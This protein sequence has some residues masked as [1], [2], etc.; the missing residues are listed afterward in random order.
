MGFKILIIAISMSFCLGAVAPDREPD[1]KSVP[2]KLEDYYTFDKITRRWVWNEDYEKLIKQRKRIKQ[3]KKQK[4]KAMQQEEPKMNCKLVSSIVVQTQSQKAPPTVVPM[5]PHPI[6]VP[7][8]HPTVVPTIPKVSVPQQKAEKDKAI[9]KKDTVAKAEKDKK[10]EKSDK[11]FYEKAWDK[12]K[13]VGRSVIHF[14]K[15]IYLKIKELIFV[16]IKKVR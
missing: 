7:V 3:L 1:V 5:P 13:K 8:P 14:F 6:V 11:K 12:T 10:D 15:I 9:E 2:A 4:L 16:I